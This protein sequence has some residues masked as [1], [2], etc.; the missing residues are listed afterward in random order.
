MREKLLSILSGSTIGFSFGVTSGK[1]IETVLLSI[2]GG[3]A[4]AAGG[5]LFKWLAQQYKNRKRKNE[6]R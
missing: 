3:L 6:Q 2:V 4:G 1:I 5:R